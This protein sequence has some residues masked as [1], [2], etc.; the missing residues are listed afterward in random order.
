MRKVLATLSAVAMVAA[1]GVSLR[2]EPKTVKGEVIDVM[3]HTKK[4]ENVGATT[5]DT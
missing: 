5:N 4:A 3:C 1:L 2:A